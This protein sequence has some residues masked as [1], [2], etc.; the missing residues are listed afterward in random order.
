[1]IKRPRVVIKKAVELLNTFPYSCRKALTN[2][3]F[4]RALIIRFGTNGD[5]ALFEVEAHATSFLAVRHQREDD[6]LKDVRYI[7]KHFMSLYNT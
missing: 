4:L 3:P 5:A 6:Y 7:R 2:N 1:M